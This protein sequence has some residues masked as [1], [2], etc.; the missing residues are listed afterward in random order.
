MVG[1]ILT[2]CDSS[3]TFLRL[4]PLANLLTLPHCPHLPLTLTIELSNRPNPTRRPAP[5]AKYP[6]RQILSL[7]AKTPKFAPKTRP[8]RAHSPPRTYPTPYS[9]ERK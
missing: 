7:A 6:P 9:N 2:Y 5:N 8:I 4:W 3:G 1:Q